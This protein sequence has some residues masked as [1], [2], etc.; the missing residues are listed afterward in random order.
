MKKRLLTLSLVSL[1]SAAMITSCSSDP[2]TWKEGV[3]LSIDGKEYKVSDIFADYDSN[4]DGA[5]AYYEAINNV[6]VWINQDMTSTMEDSVDAKMD[7]FEKSVSDNASNNGTSEKEEREALL[8]SLGFETME[9]LRNSY[10]LEIKKTENNDDFYSD[11]AYTK[12]NG[13]IDNLIENYHP[14]HVRHV[15]VNID[16]SGDAIVDGLISEDDSKQLSNVVERLASGEE[17][18]GQV[19]Q[20]SSDDTN[21][22]AIFGDVGIMTTQ[23]SFVSE[24]K[25]GLYAYDAYFNPTLSAEQKAAAK[26][27]LAIPNEADGVIGENLYGIP[28]YAFDKFD[29]YADVTKS[30]DKTT[31]EYASEVNYPRNII[32]NKYLNNHGTSLIYYAN[33]DGTVVNE[34]DVPSRYKKF[35]NTTLL[36]NSNGD[37]ELETTERI[38]VE[39]TK[40]ILCDEAGNPILVTRA[41]DGNGESGYQG[42][43]FI[44]A[45]RDPFI[46]SDKVKDYYTLD[47]PST[48]T[49]LEDDAEP[50]YINFINTTDRS[51]YTK[52]QGLIKEAANASYANI[53]F[54]IFRTNLAAAQKEHNVK[55]NGDI[56]N[57]V[58]KYIASV[59]DTS[60]SN[61]A[62]NYEKSW[63]TYL[64]KL[65]LHQSLN[66]RILPEGCITEFENGEINRSGVCYVK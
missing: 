17:S 1:M 59:E 55:I 30:S 53:N 42:I 3:L 4:I 9:E 22:A 19:A 7:D 50:T 5:R 25:Y 8:T 34:S 51:V 10:I 23:T 40:Y 57:L 44:I 66:G 21:S 27:A 63:T 20:T 64:D 12:D 65:S 29:E 41:G 26:A 56:M 35:E 15:L 45:Q 52:R 43:H 37:N 46:D 61:T 18:F 2:Y 6:L 62:E 33:E 11:E 39:G 49:N 48:T 31:V 14:Y 24:F 28:S 47:I 38:K 58:N 54:E 36:V 16:A 13:L 32:F 60:A